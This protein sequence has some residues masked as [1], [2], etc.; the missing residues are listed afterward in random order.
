M[1]AVQLTT[2]FNELDD[3]FTAKARKPF[4]N[5][6]PEQYLLFVQLK[7]KVPAVV[8]LTLHIVPPDAHATSCEQL[9]S[10]YGLI[11]TRLRNKLGVEK[12]RKTSLVRG[13]VRRQARLDEERNA[14]DPEVQRKKVRLFC[15]L[16]L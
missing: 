8:R 13:E 16:E 10:E 11:I 15:K 3:C 5:L 12:A 7:K 14:D 9:F 4:E 2:V 6:G 1:I